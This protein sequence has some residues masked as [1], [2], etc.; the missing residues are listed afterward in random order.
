MPPAPPTIEKKAVEELSMEYLHEI[1]HTEQ[2]KIGKKKTKVFQRRWNT[3]D[4]LW[5]IL[6][7][8][9]R[10]ESN[11]SS[12]D[13]NGNDTDLNGMSMVERLEN[14][15]EES[16]NIVL[17]HCLQAALQQELLLK[18][19]SHEV[20]VAGEQGTLIQAI[21]G[22]CLQSVYLFSRLFWLLKSLA[23]EFKDQQ[24]PC[25]DFFSAM[26]KMLLKNHSHSVEHRRTIERL[27]DA[28]HGSLLT[29]DDFILTNARSAVLSLNEESVW[30]G[31]NSVTTPGVIL[32]IV[33]LNVETDP[34]RYMFPKGDILLV[35]GRQV[36]LFGAIESA[37]RLTQEFTSHVQQQE[38]DHR[39]P[40]DEGLLAQVN[41]ALPLNLSTM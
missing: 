4:T 18:S 29:E 1:F 26:K 7:A 15:S 5:S 12:S 8:V 28:R 36:L 14:L 31:Q 38:G 34:Y 2:P 24:H 30:N 10:V 23:D 27:L 40:S 16:M 41:L 13:G 32:G 3:L 25:H 22:R 17:P 9:V 33:S 19:N 20:H 39:T 6:D 21:Q 11:K 37:R 35:I